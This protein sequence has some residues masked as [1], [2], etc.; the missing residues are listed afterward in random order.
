MKRKRKK[1]YYFLLFYSP[2]FIFEGKIKKWEVK[3][4][5]EEHVLLLISG[6]INIFDMKTEMFIQI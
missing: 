6:A 5:E 4:G 3:M 1:I 2:I